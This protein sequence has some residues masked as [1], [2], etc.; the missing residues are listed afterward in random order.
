MII[1]SEVV[2]RLDLYVLLLVYL[3]LNGDTLPKKSFRNI[4]WCFVLWQWIK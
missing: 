3:K 2:Y 4:T 1:I